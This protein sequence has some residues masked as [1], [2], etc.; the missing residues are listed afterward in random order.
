MNSSSLHHRS[1]ASSNEHLPVVSLINTALQRG[2]RNEV[3]ENRLNGF[4]PF[5]TCH[6]TEARRY[7]NY[8][9]TGR[10]GSVP[11]KTIETRSETAFHL[12]LGMTN[13]ICRFETR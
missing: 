7:S 5:W 3:N 12:T 13:L 1:D 10:G 9:I 6:R 8:G 4:P 2:V 11:P